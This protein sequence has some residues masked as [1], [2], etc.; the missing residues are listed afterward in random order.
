MGGIAAAAGVVI[1]SSRD[2]TDTHDLFLAFD[3]QSGDARWQ[4]SYPAPGQLDYGN[5][6]RATP[7][8][9]DELVYL[10][11]AFGMLT[12]ADLA[13][14]IVLWQ[15]DLAA[16][17]ATPSLDWGLAG[18][19]LMVE[20]KLLVQPGGA[21]GS[22]AALDP[23]SGETV[24]ATGSSPPGHSSLVPCPWKEGTQ[25]VGY[26]KTSLGG[27]DP[28]TG[29]RLWSLAPLHPGDFNVPTPIVLQDRLF[30]A[31]ENN[32]ARL[33]QLNPDGRPAPQPLARYDDLVP[34]SHSP[35][36]AAG[37][38]FGVANGLHC[39]NAEDL[40]PLWVAEENEFYE[41]ASLLASDER[42][43]CLT[44]DC[45]LLLIDARADSYRELGRLQLTADGTETLSHPALANR[46]LFVRAGLQ[47]LCLQLDPAA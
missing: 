10:F 16:E 8:I 36:A 18:S 29:E 39:L 35:V 38:I 46:R 45:Q 26:D 9:H 15:R 41:Y 25:V 13:T 21:R 6:P 40:Q 1:V 32:G 24:W 2:F 3:Q 31:T 37:R 11:G 44:I 34:D 19:P 22:I 17:F 20:D 43:L 30:V 23:L 7:L 33:Y 12:C 4:V 42:L 5:S 14:G 28:A 47:L 27:W